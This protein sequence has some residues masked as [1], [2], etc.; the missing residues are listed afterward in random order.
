MVNFERREQFSADDVDEL[1]NHLDGH[2]L[3]MDQG[4]RLSRAQSLSSK[5]SSRASIASERS[6]LSNVSEKP[7]KP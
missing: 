5:Q 1:R 6:N 2:L 4:S 7:W 3:S